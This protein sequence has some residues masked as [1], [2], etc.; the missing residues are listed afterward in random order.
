MVSYMGMATA[1]ISV[2]VSRFVTIALEQGERSKA[3]RVFN[4]AQIG[5]WG[6][7]AALLVPVGLV[8]FYGDRL[9]RVPAGSE[10]DVRW[11]FAFCGASFLTST[12]TSAFGVSAFC[13]NRLDIQAWFSIASTFARVGLVWLLFQIVAAKLWQVGAGLLLAAMVSAIGLIWAWR[14]LAPE[15][16]IRFADWDVK[17]LHR[18]TAT[19]GWLSVWQVG[20]ILLISIDLLVVNRIFGPVA[21]T[22]YAVAL[23]W[24]V[25]LR[26][27]A[28][29][30]GNLFAP[31]ITALHARN[32]VDGVVNYSLRSVKFLG[33][34]MALPIGL[35]SGLAR[36]LLNTWLGPDFVGV[37]PLMILL[38]LPMAL[39][40][41]YLPIQQ[42]SLATNNVRLPGLVQ[43][44]A[45]V[46]NLVLAIVLARFTPLGMYGV[47]LA[48]G[49]VLSL[50]NLLFTPIYS[51]RILG[52][53][54]GTFFRAMAP[55]LVASGTAFGTAWLGAVY[56]T[57]S[58][59]FQ[60]GATGA[61]TSLLY[62]ATAYLFL[63]S[64]P[65][66]EEVSQ[67]ALG[68]IRRFS[69]W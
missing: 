53:S 61:V 58:G 3:N 8:S 52:V 31:E 66:K 30:L 64:K 35:I 56:F 29:T 63:L 24:S 23:Q 6:I 17:E 32:N 60:L 46:L 44:V 7:S 5:L 50:R 42:I 36:P 47:A 40:L 9:V 20:T 18:L 34:L 2:A 11:L 13:R 65:E 62:G 37:A 28:I 38:T 19:T 45:G 48:G 59:W 68:Y 1:G 16:R 39:N 51:A 41:A 57:P 27:I 26:G 4:T 25:M 54:D 69:G 14:H 15:L 12:A 43:I 10:T 21:G 55:C 49:L 22:L 67:R 33:L